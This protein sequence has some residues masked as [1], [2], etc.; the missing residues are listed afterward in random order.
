MEIICNFS[1]HFQAHSPIIANQL[2]IFHRHCLQRA[3]AGTLTNPQKRTVNTRS[4]IQPGSCC[5][6]YHLMEIIM[7]MPLQQLR[8]HAC[9]KSQAIYDASYASR[10]RCTRIRHSIPHSITHTDFDRHTRFLHNAHQFRHKGNHKAIK[11]SPGN[12]LQMTPRANAI[13]N[14]I[15]YNSQ[16]FIHRLLTGQP[17]LIKNMIIGA[18]NKDSRFLNADAFYQLK[19]I[20]AGPNPG[21]N[22]RK[23]IIHFHALFQCFSILF[24]IYKKFTLTNDP[25]FAAQSVHQF[26]QM[27]N[28]LYRKRLHSL[29]AI[30][31]GCIRNPD[32]IREMHGHQSVVKAC[33]WH[34]IVGKTIPEQHGLFY[35]LQIIVIVVFLQKICS[36]ILF[37]YIHFVILN[38]IHQKILLSWRFPF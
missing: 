20:F 1:N 18:G 26:I 30:A 21:C 22:F 25:A 38:S 4:T 29:L 33:F 12:I 14:G 37:F 23:V 15:L 32:M 24:R 3:I 11:I 9:I 13:G 2:C 7:A 5:I 28:L 36:S 16:I 6:D 35:I 17:H 8:W 31:K 27:Q 10:Q 34:L 19:I